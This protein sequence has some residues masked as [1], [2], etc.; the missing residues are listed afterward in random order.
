MEIHAGPIASVTLKVCSGLFKD[1]MGNG[2]VIS[3]VNDTCV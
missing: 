3:D 1:E 2:Q